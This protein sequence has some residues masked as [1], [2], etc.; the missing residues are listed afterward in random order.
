V[1]KASRYIWKFNEYSSSSDINGCELAI[2]LC[3]LSSFFV[4]SP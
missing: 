4:V 2:M 3:E 1:L